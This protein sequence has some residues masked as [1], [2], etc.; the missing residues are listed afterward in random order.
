MPFIEGCYY[1]ESLEI[2]A[3]NTNPIYNLGGSDEIE[4]LNN[5]QQENESYRIFYLF[6]GKCTIKFENHIIKAEDD[7]LVFSDFDQ[8]FSA[9]INSNEEFS[10]LYIK[11]NPLFFKN[12]AGD[13]DFTRAF[14]IPNSK[15]RVIYPKKE[16][17]G[18]LAF[19]AE[20]IRKCLVKH[21]GPVH[22]YCRINAIISELDI[23]YDEEQKRDEV[24]T[25]N[26]EVKLNNYIRRHYKEKLTLTK[27]ENKFYLS[28][29]SINAILKRN[30]GYTFLEYLNQLRLKCALQY[31]NEGLLSYKKIA[32]LSGFS[33]YTAFFRTY[34]KAFGVSPSDNEN[35]KKSEV[36]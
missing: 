7:A 10:Y 31:M 28:S 5:I 9:S 8:K 18:M 14:N 32:E 4:L 29:T 27:L 23:L 11:I 6:K 20:S 15:R 12:I 16:K 3:V 35:N 36:K 1:D 26:I 19:L 24:A 21:L 22:I 2:S 34:K 30:V 17:S 13:H 33:D 25:D